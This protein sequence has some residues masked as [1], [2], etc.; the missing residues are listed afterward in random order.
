MLGSY[1]IFPMVMAEKYQA[2]DLNM[3]R[4]DEPLATGGNC[5]VVPEPAWFGTSNRRP[6]S[7]DAAS[8]T[9]YSPPEDRLAYG[10]ARAIRASHVYVT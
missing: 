7:P 3:I 8:V 2:D 4:S 6:A 10:S 5:R 1:E 9:A